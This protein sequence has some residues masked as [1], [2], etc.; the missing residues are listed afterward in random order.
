MVIRAV[1]VLTFARPASIWLLWTDMGVVCGC[2]GE[3]QRC[4][5]VRPS[6][7]VHSIYSCDCKNLN[8]EDQVCSRGNVPIRKAFVGIGFSGRDI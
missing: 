5:L 6:I 8:L 1:K 7:A 3:R 4:L 2:S